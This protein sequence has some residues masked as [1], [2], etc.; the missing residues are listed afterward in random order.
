MLNLMQTWL[1]ALA[2]KANIEK[3]K[4]RELGKK[5]IWYSVQK[6]KDIKALFS[7]EGEKLP[8]IG[9]LSSRSSGE[10]TG[11]EW[12]YDFT[13][14]EFD[15]ENNFLGVRLAVEIEMSDSKLKGLVYDFNKLLQSDAPYKA[16]IFQQK[17]VDDYKKI[18]KPLSD[19]HKA[20][21]H[22]APSQLLVACW[23]TSQYRFEYCVLES[24]CNQ[25]GETKGAA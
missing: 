9:R 2:D 11:R 21:H 15:T 3:Q 18:R 22:R 23:I 14:R 7:S 4:H 25:S 6:N 1:N 5:Y 19:A 10:S 13:L 24:P 17:T 16:F 20:Y 12:L 8:T